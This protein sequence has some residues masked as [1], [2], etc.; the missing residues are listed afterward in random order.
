MIQEVDA[1]GSGD[2]DFPELISLMARKMKHEDTGAKVIEAFKVFDREGRG[3]IAIEDLKR[4]MANLGDKL[5][6][7]E[8]D[9]IIQE[10]DADGNGVIDSEEFIRMMMAQ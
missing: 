6:E 1:D 3:E 7:D 5:T 2:L 8:V 10:A 9:S 4:V